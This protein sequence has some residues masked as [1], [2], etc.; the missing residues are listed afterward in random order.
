MA[1][2]KPTDVQLIGQEVAIRWS[3]G[4]ED[5]I[6]MERLRAWS[7]SAEN[8]GEPD[9]FGRIHGADPRDSFPGV[10]VVG[11][12]LVGTYAIR[13]IFSDRHQSGLYSYAYLR[14]LGDYVAE[15]AT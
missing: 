2:F 5:F 4:R 11:W 8:M 7:P 3:D 14:R 9:I 10:T 12:E 15:D 1:G 6:P 13:F